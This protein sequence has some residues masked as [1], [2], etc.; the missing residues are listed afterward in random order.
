M[1]TRRA[2][3]HVVLPAELV[4]EIDALVGPRQRSRF[5]A[6]AAAERLQRER[7]LKVLDECFGAWKPEDHP[8]LDGPEGAAGWVR[9]LRDEEDRC[10]ETLLNG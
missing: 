5:I 10:R 7:T 8:E 2:R 3:S 1:S 6:E 9:R 4:A